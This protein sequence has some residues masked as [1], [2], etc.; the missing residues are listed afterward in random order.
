MQKILIKAKNAEQAIRTCQKFLSNN[1][2][3]AWAYQAEQV[4][5]DTLERLL[6]NQYAYLNTIEKLGDTPAKDIPFEL[7]V[8]YVG[9]RLGEYME[10][11]PFY[12]LVEKSY[13]VYSPL[14]RNYFLVN[15][16]TTPAFL[17]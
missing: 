9:T 10:N 12:N 17:N 3:E 13:W 6:A 8:H 5:P 2:I 11:L 14:K 4:R 15:V 16:R 7:L 1:A